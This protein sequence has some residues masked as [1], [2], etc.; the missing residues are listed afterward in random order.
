MNER[1]QKLIEES[2]LDYIC[3]DRND[4]VWVGNNLKVEKFSELIIKEC[5]NVIKR[6]MELAHI[7]LVPINFKMYANNRLQRT[8][9]E[10]FGVE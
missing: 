6:D 5:V 2:G 8:I 3:Y 4:E 9:K 7:Q 1:I 10:C